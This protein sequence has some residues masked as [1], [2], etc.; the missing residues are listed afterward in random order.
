MAQNSQVS[1]GIDGMSCA[2]CVGRVDRTLSSMGGVSDVAVNLASESARLTVDDP[3]RLPEVAET[4]DK[5]GYPARTTRVT[6]NI[7]SMSCASCVG[8]VDKALADLPD[9]F[10][11]RLSSLEATEADDR[12][13]AIMGDSPRICPH[14]HLPLQS[15][16]ADV[17]RRM[18][19]P[20]TPGEFLRHVARV[21][22]RL[23]LPAVTTDVIVGFPGE[24][25]DAFEDTY[26]FIERSPL[27]VIGIV[28]QLGEPTESE[29]PGYAIWVLA[30]R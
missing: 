13:L 8:R 4:L 23:A 20:Y 17:L 27:R 6:L 12:L 22:E 1:L 7:E 3:A 10:R 25:D 2:S 5:L 14:L 26:R 30:P 9:P 18:R 28:D 11:I 29:E 24:T 16:S 21:R 15:G 19:R